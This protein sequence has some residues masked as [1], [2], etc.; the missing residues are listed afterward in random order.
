[1]RHRSLA[2]LFLLCLPA[3]ALAD[4][5]PGKPA[6]AFEI[7]DAHGQV[8]KLS[9]YQGKWLVLEWYNKDCPYVRK[10]YGSGNMQTLQQRYTSQ[11]VA[12]LSVI[13]SAPGKQ[14]YQEPMEA[15]DTAKTTKSA[16]LQVLLD[17]SGTMGK[18]YGAKTTPHMFVID[19]QGTVVY[20]GGID[21]NDSS[22]PAVIPTSKNYVSAALDAALAGQKIATAS[23]RP[24][25]C[26]VQY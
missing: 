7:K 24:Y 9:D 6:P 12:W 1:M 21:D 25:G 26:H 8:Q 16:A 14:G 5:V 20:A 19:P 13:S 2:L 23:A 4:A 15:L 10:H 18:A 22:N 11:G 3:L 17:T